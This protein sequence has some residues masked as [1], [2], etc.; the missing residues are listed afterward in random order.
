MLKSP[1]LRCLL[2]ALS[3]VAAASRAGAQVLPEDPIRSADGRL[4]VSA[5]LVGTF[6][7]QDD[8]AFFNY[9]D[10]EHN[11][12]RMFRIGTAGVW[13]PM[14]WL[15]LAGEVRSEDLDHP[16]VYAAYARIKPWQDRGLTIDVG[17]IPP[18]F[19]AFSRHAYTT[20]NPVI[21]YPLAYQYLTSLRTDAVPAVAD[22]LLRMRARGWRSSF[23]I[24]EHGAGPGCA[25]HQ[26]L[27]LGHRRP[28]GMAGA[29]GSR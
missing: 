2:V 18:T 9:T 15:A 10:Y 28:G 25:A 17:R 16:G 7:N 12:L 8:V 6:G 27:P 11:A 5:E 13:R 3:C 1:H 4:V 26:R 14:P 23:P 29:G 22:D 24:G 20:D 19:G 21:G